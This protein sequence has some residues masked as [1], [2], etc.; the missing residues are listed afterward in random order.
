[1]KKNTLSFLLSVCSFLSGFAQ[2]VS[3]TPNRYTAHN[4]GKFFVFWGGN[5]GYY[6][7]SDIQF[8]GNGYNFTL[9]DVEAL[10]RPKAGTLI[11]S[12]LSE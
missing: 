11:T 3:T 2:K 9:S 8:K 1:M 6:S 4:K 5:R 7:K 10:D 12:I